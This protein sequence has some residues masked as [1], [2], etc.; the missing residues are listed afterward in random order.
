LG[1]HTNISSSVADILVIV[2][3]ILLNPAGPFSPSVPP[4]IPDKIEIHYR[5]TLS[6]DS[7]SSAIALAE[8]EMEEIG[9]YMRVHNVT[10]EGYNLIAQYH[11]QLQQETRRLKATLRRLQES[12][13]HNKNTVTHR[14]VKVQDRP[15]TAVK[16]QNGFWRAGL[17]H[18]KPL[19][20]EA[21]MR[22]R[23]GRIVC[24]RFDSDTIVTARRRDSLGVYQG[25]MDRYAMASG[26]GVYDGNDGS[27]YEGMWQND[28]RHGFGFESSP[29]H[30]VRIGQWKDGRFLGEKLRYTTERIYGIDI[31]RHQHEQGRKRYGINFRNMQ[32]TSLGKRH[33]NEGRSFPVSFVYIKSTEGTSIRNR[34]FANDYMHAKKEGLRVGAYH[35]FSLKSSAADQANYFVS[36]TLFRAGDFPPVLDVEPSD[37]QIAQIGGDDELMRRIRIFLQ[38]VERR[39]GMRPILYINQMF[40]NNHMKQAS[41]IKQK[42]N[43]WIARYGEYKPDVK[44]VYWQL[45]PDGRVNGI[46]GPVDINVFNG[47]QGQ[48]DE[49]V[50]TGFH[51]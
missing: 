47:Y 35:F 44:L 15:M 3:L 18:A 28:Q 37:A 11:T 38:I 51:K 21:I 33:D 45:C 50:R 12:D 39:T 6:T 17:F 5:P 36:N 30:Q 25:Q 34:Y 9:Y 20:G 26:Q 48:Y 42:Y 27:H 10:D 19:T 2:V 49:F 32:I 40:I 22:D 23:Q 29:H 43:V 1:K 46:T 16:T 4:S 14:I 8:Q 31:S 24:A 13:S 41:D 7:I